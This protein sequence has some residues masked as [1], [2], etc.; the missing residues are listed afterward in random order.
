MASVGAALVLERESDLGSEQGDLAAVNTTLAS[1][2]L[3][4]V[5]D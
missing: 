5:G 1:V 4:I 2:G 3:S